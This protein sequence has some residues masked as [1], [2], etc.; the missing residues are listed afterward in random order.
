MAEGCPRL[1]AKGHISRRSRFQVQRIQGSR[2]CWAGPKGVV[3]L[4]QD[5]VA[6][7]DFF[8]QNFGKDLKQVELCVK[9]WNWG[10]PIFK[11]MTCICI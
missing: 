11:G 2:E 1:R 6:V 5:F 3:H 7:R 10:E 8:K 4:V 9:G